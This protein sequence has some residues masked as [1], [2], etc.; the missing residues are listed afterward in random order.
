MKASTR[1]PMSWRYVPLRD[2]GLPAEEQTA[3][4]LRPMTLPERAAAHDEL[5]RVQ[6][7]PDGTRTVQARTRQVAARLAREHVTAIE[8]FP[9]GA[10]QPWPTTDDDRQKYLELLDDD[11][12]LELGNEI[13]ERSRFGPGDPAKN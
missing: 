8:N 2:R 1:P 3:F 4:I 7:A 6:V 9:G 13:Y 5:A 12:V 11:V 10:P